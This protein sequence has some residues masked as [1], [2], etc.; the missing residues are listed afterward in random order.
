MYEKYPGVKRRVTEYRERERMAILMACDAVVQA[1]HEG[2]ERG[3]I[4]ALLMR[5]RQLVSEARWRRSA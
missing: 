1:V 4:D 2:A 5:Q 3:I